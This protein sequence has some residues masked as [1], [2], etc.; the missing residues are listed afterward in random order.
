[1]GLAKLTLADVNRVI[2]KHLQSDNIQFVFIAKDASGLKAALESATPSPITY[3]SP[4]PELAAEDAIISKLP[5][6]LNEVL[7]KPGDSVFK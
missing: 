7:I 5:L 4:K 1:E 6:S 2:E 3:N